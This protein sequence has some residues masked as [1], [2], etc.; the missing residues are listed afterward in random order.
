MWAVSDRCLLWNLRGERHYWINPSATCRFQLLELV[1]QDLL[2]W[3]RHYRTYAVG[4][5][6]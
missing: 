6:N 5:A 3:N 4:C 1:T 2:H